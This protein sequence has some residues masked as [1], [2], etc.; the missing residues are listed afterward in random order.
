MKKAD[1]CYKTYVTVTSYVGIPTKHPI[2][3]PKGHLHSYTG[4]SLSIWPVKFS[5][6]RL[7]VSHEHVGDSELMDESQKISW[8]VDP[9]ARSATFFTG[10]R[11]IND[12]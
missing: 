10:H 7:R 8:P 9:T 11:L 12:L 3:L 4:H 2:K 1:K 6:G 5:I